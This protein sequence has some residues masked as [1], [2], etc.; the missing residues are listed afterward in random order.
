M[1]TASFFEKS[2]IVYQSTERLILEDLNRY[3]LVSL[4]RNCN[5][6]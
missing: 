1:A 6:C 2:V 5:L 4:E 3:E